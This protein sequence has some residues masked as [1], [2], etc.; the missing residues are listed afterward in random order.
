V[1]SRD[2]W[3]ATTRE[4][5]RVARVNEV[6]LFRQF[7]TK[8]RL[9]A[10]VA[11]KLVSRQIEAL[12]SVDLHD[13]NLERDLYRIAEAYDRSTSEHA[14][15]VRMLLSRAAEPDLTVQITR[16]V[17]R[18]LRERFIQYLEEARRRGLVR[19]I[20]LPQ[21]VDAFTGMVFTGALRRSIRRQ[22]YNR[23]TYLRTCVDLFLRGIAS[24]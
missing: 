13:F 14:G 19:D 8:E 5:A 24:R 12:E 18:P 22:D 21:A 16:E 20:D 15:F 4:I 10:E 17:V 6:T 1:F 23:Q 3:Q 9:L 7:E 11:R 2:G